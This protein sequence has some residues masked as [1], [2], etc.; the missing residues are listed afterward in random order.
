M[1]IILG[2]LGSL[3]TILILLNRLA[4]AGIDLGG[5]NPFLWQRRRRW[6]KKIQGNPVYTI[7][8]PLDVTALLATATA[9]SDGDMSADEK[10]GLLA[11]FQKEF[12]ISKRDAAELIISSVYLLGNGEEVRTNLEKILNP[13]LDNF[14]EEQAKSA[15]DLLNEVCN[16]DPD[17]NELK[18]D[19]VERVSKVFDKRFQVQGKWA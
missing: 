13:S 18:H 14:T 5:F 10:K 19:L 4:E 1:H 3:I 11:L 15:A 16:I 7:E 12:N 17:E 9:K 2:F 8:S 6:K